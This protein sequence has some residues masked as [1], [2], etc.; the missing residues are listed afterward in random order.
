MPLILPFWN[1]SKLARLTLNGI[2]NSGIA[3]YLRH[4]IEPHPCPR[5]RHPAKRNWL[6]RHKRIPVEYNTEYEDTG[7]KIDSIL[8][9]FSSPQLLSWLEFWVWDYYVIS[10]WIPKSIS[11]SRSRFLQRT[12][13]C[14]VRRWRPVRCFHWWPLKAVD[15]EKRSRLCTMPLQSRML[16]TRTRWK[17]LPTYLHTYTIDSIISIIFV[18]FR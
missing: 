17:G 14:L 3:T 12:C 9:N 16:C 15:N 8:G 4:R 6:V 5:L 10:P 7:G 1:T 18:L 2:P 13:E 11:P